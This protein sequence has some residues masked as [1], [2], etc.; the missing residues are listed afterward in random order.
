LFLL[1]FS[2]F[3]SSKDSSTPE[4]LQGLYAHTVLPLLIF[5]TT[6]KIPQRI[7]P[8]ITE[9]KEFS[10]PVP[11]AQC[12][13]AYLEEYLLHRT[14]SNSILLSCAPMHSL[15]AHLAELSQNPQ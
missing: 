4:P 12:L 7:L 2:P 6:L 11:S 15:D 3:E 5:S 1:R 14:F 9:L 8:S 10:S 13:Y